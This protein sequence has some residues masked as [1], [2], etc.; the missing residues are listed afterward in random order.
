MYIAASFEELS[1][2]AEAFWYGLLHNDLL[3][4]IQS[5]AFH[6][7]H[8]AAVR[9]LG[10]KIKPNY[11]AALLKKGKGSERQKLGA[12]PSAKYHFMPLTPKMKGWS[13]T[14]CSVQQYLVTIIAYKGSQVGQIWCCCHAAGAHTDM[15]FVRAQA[16]NKHDFPLR[17]LLLIKDFIWKYHKPEGR[18]YFSFLVQNLLQMAVS[19]HDTTLWKVASASFI[20]LLLAD[21]TQPINP[22]PFYIRVFKFVLHVFLP[23]QLLTL[24]VINC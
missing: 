9:F 5:Q 12:S 19:A 17:S 20:L 15:P 21:S 18:R 22:S 16:T 13:F 23:L 7:E 6:C 11:H 24:E 2:S 3:N 14:A 4:R 10:K 8:T 1:F